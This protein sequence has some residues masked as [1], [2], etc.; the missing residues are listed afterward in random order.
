M[1]VELAQWVHNGEVAI[2]G[3]RSQRKDGD[4][5]GDILH[6]LRYAAQE[7]APGPILDGVDGGDEG[8]SCQYDQQV[9]Q[10]Q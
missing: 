10:C 2:T 7:A 8:H 5:N 6:E 4:S 9:C 1:C 3:E